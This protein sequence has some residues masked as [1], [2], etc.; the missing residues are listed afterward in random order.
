MEGLKTWALLADVSPALPHPQTFPGYGH[1]LDILDCSTYLLVL[2]TLG[3]PYRALSFPGP[4]GTTSFAAD[5]V[6]PLHVAS[7]RSALARNP[8]TDIATV[9]RITTFPRDQSGSP[10]IAQWLNLLSHRSTARRRNPHPEPRAIPSHRSAHCAN[11]PCFSLA[12]PASLPRRRLHEEQSSGDSFES[13]P[14]STS[15]IQTPT[16]SSARSTTLSKHL[17]WLQ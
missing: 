6:Q 15:Q 14:N 12:P 5:S 8:G 4:I 10:H 16:S 1:A 11:C 2:P 13:S 17:T 9:R 7:R 3:R